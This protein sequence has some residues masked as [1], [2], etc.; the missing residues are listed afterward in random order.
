MNDARRFPDGPHLPFGRWHGRH[1]WSGSYNY[2]AE[3]R[4]PTHQ[5]CCACRAVLPATLEHFYRCTARWSGL[6]GYCKSCHNAV[7]Y[8][9]YRRRRAALPP[10]PPT[11]APWTPGELGYAASRSGCANVAA[12]MR[13]VSRTTPTLHVEPSRAGRGSGARAITASTS[14]GTRTIPACTAIRD[15]PRTSSCAFDRMGSG[16]YTAAPATGPMGCAATTRSRQPD[17]RLPMR[18]SAAFK[19]AVRTQIVPTQKHLAALEEVAHWTVLPIVMHLTCVYLRSTSAGNER[20]CD[21]GTT[22]S[23]HGASCSEGHDTRRHDAP[24]R[25]A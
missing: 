6:T 18:R 13:R 1:R 19:A 16:S 24:A 14:P 11:P 12:A 5:R 23:V 2:A 17:T 3:P 8:R 21:D 22:R 25:S 7:S 20:P 10:K 4:R 15:R 9:N